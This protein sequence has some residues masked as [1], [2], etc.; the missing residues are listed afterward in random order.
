[1]LPALLG[2]IVT[3]QEQSL[4]I[5]HYALLDISALQEPRVKTNFLAQVFD[6]LTLF[7]FENDQGSIMSIYRWHLQWQ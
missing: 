4:E 5:Q 2:T 6:L 1:M 3:Q 7:E